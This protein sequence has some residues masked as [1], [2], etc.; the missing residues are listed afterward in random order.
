MNAVKVTLIVCLTVLISV[1]VFMVYGEQHERYM[2]FS[3]PQEKA[4][5]VLD[6]NNN[7]LNY[8]TPESQCVLIPLQIPVPFSAQPIMV[9]SPSVNLQPSKATVPSTNSGSSDIS[10]MEPMQK[11]I[12]SDTSESSSGSNDDSKDESNSGE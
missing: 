12:D 3:I 10:G 4:L 9:G 7:T 6:K 2:V 1:A 5:Y 11:P 8:C